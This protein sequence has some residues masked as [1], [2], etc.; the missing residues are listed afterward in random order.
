MS[1]YITL[2]RLWFPREGDL[3]S[4]CGWI[5]VTAQGVPPHVGSPSPGAGYE[6]GDPF[7]SFLPS[8]VAVD[9]NGDAP[10]MRGVVFVTEHTLK[11]TT[12]SPQEYVSPLL[13]LSGEEYARIT[14]EDL[15]GRICDALRGNLAPL[16]A[17]I[18][19]PDGARVLIRDRGS[20]GE[21]GR[22]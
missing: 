9:K 6:R 22:S 10:L 13:V 1:I 5:A 20:N 15:H 11:G 17:E 2:W 8:P 19:R 14:F 12:R 21:A 16:A 7:A 4:E 3:H 18:I